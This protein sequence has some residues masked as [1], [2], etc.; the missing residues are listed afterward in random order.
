MKKYIYTLALSVLA[1]GVSLAQQVPMFSHNYYKPFLYN[2]SYAGASNQTSIFVFSRNQWTGVEGAPTTQAVT[3]DGA[4][5]PNKAG[6]GGSVIYDKSGLFTIVNALAAYSYR[7]DFSQKSNIYFGLSAG[8]LNT[9][10]DF[11]NSVVKD[12]NDPMLAPQNSTL[13]DATFGTHINIS[14]F[15]FGIAL[16][17]LMGSS[18]STFSDKQSLYYRLSRQYML[19]AKYNLVLSPNTRIEPMFICRAQ[20]GTPFQFD[21]NLVAY[22]K[23]D[24][25]WAGAMYRSYGAISPML[26]VKL[27]EQLTLGYAYD[28]AFGTTYNNQAKQTHEIMLGF[29]FKKRNDDEQNKKIDSDSTKKCT[30]DCDSVKKMLADHEKRIDSLE[31]HEDDIASM[32]HTLTDFKRLMQTEEGRHQ[33]LVGDQYILKT[34][35]FDSRQEVRGSNNEELNELA[36]ILKDHPTFQIQLTGHTD[37]VGS[38][39]YNNNLSNHRAEWAMNY[40]I[41]KG[42][43]PSRLTA[44][45]FGKKQP[46]VSNRTEKGRALNRRVEFIV[47]KK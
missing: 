39:E 8:V 1:V 22:F 29:T 7:V 24:K 35:Y 10:F 23:Q 18:S 4:L 27:H 30:M 34:V 12:L 13:F 32:R 25:I 41:G 3:V 33:I 28:H 40:L 15:Q 11:S 17:H 6:L 44:K 38:D 26:G 2:P 43:A 37:D 46:I 5:K 21:A 9:G 31:S 47:T 16:P 36:Q 19:N 14:Q 20:P 45:G 42:I